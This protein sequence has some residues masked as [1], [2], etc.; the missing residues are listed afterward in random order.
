MSDRLALL[1]DFSARADRAV[2]AGRY[3]AV[4]GLS[5]LYAAPGYRESRLVKLRRLRRFGTMT[6]IRQLL[7]GMEHLTEAFP[8]ALQELEV[9]SPDRFCVEAEQ[10]TVYYLFRWWLK[11][12]CD[13]YLW[14]QA[15]A[16]A[17]SV[18]TVCGLA[19]SADF[20]ESARL[21]AKELEHSQ[22]N[23]SALRRAMEL[24][25]FS[26]RQLLKLLEGSHAV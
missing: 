9:T 13:G 23:L 4:V 1:L 6:R 7:L 11:A 2:E 20:K 10:L 14:R 24:P 22:D 19:R 21:Y 18:L 5:D 16:A 25:Q 3:R 26:L 12:A 15:A 8:A 17:V